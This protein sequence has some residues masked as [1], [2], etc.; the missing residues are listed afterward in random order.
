MQSRCHVISGSRTKSNS[1]V[2]PRT[3]ACVATWDTCWKR[4]LQVPARP[5]T[6]KLV[7]SASQD[8]LHFLF[9]LSSFLR[10]GLLIS[11]ISISEVFVLNEWKKE[12]KEKEKNHG[13]THHF[14]GSTLWQTSISRWDLITFRNLH[15]MYPSHWKKMETHVWDFRVK[16]TC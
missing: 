14:H 8:I 2:F 13:P 11:K 15:F 1:A 16:K 5:C 7:H 6:R 10:S 12:R 4:C 9:V 3:K